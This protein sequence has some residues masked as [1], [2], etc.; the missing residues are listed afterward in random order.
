MTDLVRHLVWTREGWI[1]LYLH[2]QLPYS[3]ILPARAAL[4]EHVKPFMLGSSGTRLLSQ[5]R[6]SAVLLTDVA[7]RHITDMLV[8]CSKLTKCS[9][10]KGCNRRC[11]CFH[12]GL[13]YTA[14]C[15]CVCVCVSSRNIILHSNACKT[16]F[17]MPKPTDIVFSQYWHY[18]NDCR[19]CNLMS[20]HSKVEEHVQRTINSK[21]HS[22]KNNVEQI[23]YHL[24]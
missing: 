12:S 6:K 4:K 14:L 11:K 9:C 1:P 3:A 13:S 5:T 24:Q 21:L 16:P 8:N 7:R 18:M 22:Y 19:Y 2:K 10:K 15:W 20:R 23:E 17:N